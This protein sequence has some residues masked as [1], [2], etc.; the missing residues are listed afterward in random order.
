MKKLIFRKFAKDTSVFF[1]IMC[2][3]IGLIVWTLQAVNYFDFVTQDGHGLK[4]YFSF[5]LLN[6]PKI[7]HRII[8]FIFFISLFYII[9]DY[10]IRNELLIFWTTGI[11]KINFA[12]KIVLLSIFL[13][14]LQILIG[15]FFS[16]LSQ[17]KAREFLKNSNIDF[18]TSL[19]KEGKF[20]N[21]VDGLTIFI[22]K[23][24]IDG[25]YSNIFI[26]DSSKSNS[27]MIYA[28]NGLLI[29]TN[30]K[31]IF[32][33]FNGKILNLEKSKINVFEFDQIDFNLAEYST[34]TILM[35]KI[36]E[37]PSKDLFKCVIRLKNNEII[38]EDRQLSCKKSI[39]NEITQE[40]FKRFYKPLYLPIIAILCC[41]LVIT[42]KNN[43]NYEKNKKIIFL[44]TFFV[45]IL[46]EASLRY[47]TASNLATLLYLI[48]P[49]IGFAV[50]YFLFNLRIKNV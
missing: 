3:T 12:N 39:T 30:N 29:D 42:S 26:D 46:S 38:P 35:P 4:T 41:F 8:P 36:Q 45:L 5:I 33:L 6:F 37:I 10:E 23:K 34:N 2:F 16:P 13:T 32:R 19:I 9:T 31:K 43:I 27:R 20:I 22:D 40:L 11:S 24:E 18:F 25:T 14:F 28:N 7:I 44:I 15:G 1:L 21:A 48:T 49:W 50:I 17:Y 47:S